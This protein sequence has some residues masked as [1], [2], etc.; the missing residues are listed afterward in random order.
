[1]FESFIVAAITVF[2]FINIVYVI[3]Q[4]I[5]NNSIMDIAWGPGF[6]LVTIIL[7]LFHKISAADYVVITVA[8]LIWGIRLA[9]HIYLRSRGKEEDFRYKKWRE[10]W[11]KKAAV[12]AYFKVFILQGAIMFFMSIPF[13]YLASNYDGSMSLLNLIGL[14]IFAAGFIFESIGDYQLKEFKKK[15][16][17]KNKFITTGLWK[18]TRHPNYFGEAVLWWG[19]ALITIQG[20]E[21][22]YIL[23]SPLLINFFLVKVSGVPMLEKKYEGNPGWEEYK[24][25]TPAFIPFIGKK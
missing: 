6:I 21:S 2:L 13:V 8:V 22:L 5:K 24:K 19:L 12:K 14:V 15:Q 18:Y 17:N 3:A 1:M 16:S 4:K 25:K 20:T 23:L 10:E 7:L 9:I 11:G